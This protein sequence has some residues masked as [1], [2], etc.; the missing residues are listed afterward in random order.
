MSAMFLKKN[1]CN[2]QSSSMTALVIDSSIPNPLIAS[3][4]NRVFLSAYVCNM[5]EMYDF[6]ITGM[7]F[8]YISQ[9]FFPLQDKISIL[10]AG[11]LTFLV[12]FLMRPLGGIL[13]GY[14]GDTHGRKK[15]LL[16]S[17]FGMAIA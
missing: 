9:F 16:L 17:V 4:S 11:S 1:V 13:F 7:M 5:F 6:L 12:G 14:I 2:R 10:L 15:A 3:R 8:P